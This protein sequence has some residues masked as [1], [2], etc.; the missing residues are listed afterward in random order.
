[1]EFDTW[2]DKEVQTCMYLSE[3]KVAEVA[4]RE[5]NT[6]FFYANVEITPWVEEEPVVAALEK[7]SCT[8]NPYFGCSEYAADCPIHGVGNG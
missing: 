1:M 3:E 6:I 8:C 7:Q 5:P 4:Q 2:H